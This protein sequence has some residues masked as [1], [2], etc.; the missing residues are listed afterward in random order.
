MA[1]EQTDSTATRWAYTN[2]LLAALLVLAYLA[3]TFAPLTPYVGSHG[4]INPVVLTTTTAAF[5]VA[6]AW[7]FGP[8]AVKAWQDF[9]GGGS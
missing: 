7:V 2:D 6:I 4:G 1:D 5:G 3:L 8:D 9:K